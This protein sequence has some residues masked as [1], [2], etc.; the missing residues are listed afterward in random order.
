M[1]VKTTVMVGTVASLLCSASSARAM[2]ADPCSLLTETQVSAA[3]GTP[4]TVAKFGSD[5]TH[6]HWEQQ[7]KHGATT[8]DAHVLVEAAKTYDAAKGM[9]GMNG[10]V[11]VVPV[12]GLGDD[13]YYLVAGKDAPLF[14]K[15]GNSAIRVA[16]AAKGASLD[17]IQAKEKALAS[18]LL[19]KL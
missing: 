17:D 12:S 6:C 5:A 2:A 10:K 16:F 4:V 8:A 9:M 18:A 13:A 15:K 7:A 3:L 1:S 19:G 11:K 14:V